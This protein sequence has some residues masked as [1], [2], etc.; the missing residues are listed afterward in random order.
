[1]SAR[2]L[3]FKNSLLNNNMRKKLCTKHKCLA[4]L[5]AIFGKNSY[6]RPVTLTTSEIP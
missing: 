3:N 6:L 2:S 4:D 5:S 1:M